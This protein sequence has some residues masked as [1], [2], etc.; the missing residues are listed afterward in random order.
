MMLHEKMAQLEKRRATT[1]GM[2]AKGVCAHYPIGTLLTVVLG[3][4]TIKGVVE[5]HGPD[6]C[7]PESVYIRNVE[8]GKRRRF[9]A[10]FNETQIIRRGPEDADL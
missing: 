9:N 5:T 8:T 7:D 6:W 4:A 2:I 10:L 1:L 3:R